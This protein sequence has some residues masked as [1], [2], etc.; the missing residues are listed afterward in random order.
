MA[1]LALV[2]LGV[3]AVHFLGYRDVIRNARRTKVMGEIETQLRHR[4]Q[5]LET[6]RV[7]VGAVTTEDE[8]WSA[9]QTLAQALEMES[10]GLD[11]DG[12]PPRVWERNVMGNGVDRVRHQDLR[13]HELI[14]KVGDQHFGRLL[15]AAYPEKELVD[16]VDSVFYQALSDG[17]SLALYRLSTM[18]N[19]LRSMPSA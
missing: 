19:Q 16:A 1:I 8:L 14:L 9:L 12:F 5:A 6:Y 17:T 4:T 7:R 18:T 3:L 2:P 10:M 15:V 11:L 13:E